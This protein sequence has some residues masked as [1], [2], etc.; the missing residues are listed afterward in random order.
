MST[1]NELSSELPLENNITISLE[2]VD[3]ILAKTLSNNRK[4]KNGSPILTEN[5]ILMDIVDTE[6]PLKKKKRIRERDHCFFCESDVLNFARHVQ[7]NHA[8]EVEVQKILSKPSNSKE[9]K[10]L[11]TSLRKKGNYIKNSQDKIKPM[12]KPVLPETKLMPCNFCLGFYASKQ[13][14]RHKK[15][16]PENHNRSSSTLSDSQNLLLKHLKLNKQLKETVF[17]KM[18]ADN[19]SLEAKKDTLICEFGARY[20]RTHPEKHFVIVTSRKIRELARLLIEIKSLES[21]INNL[22]EALQPQYFDIIIQATKI[23]A[24]YD[25]EKNRFD[26]PTYAMNI[27]TSLKQCCDIA[28]VYALKRKEVYST[29]NSAEA[30]SNLKTMIHLLESNWKF[31]ISTQAANDLNMKKWNKITIVPLASDLK[32]L[33]EHLTL[34]AD[35]AAF[36]L[37]N[38][39]NDAKA[40]GEL[41]ETIYCRIILLNRKR[42]GELQRLLVSTYED[43][44]KNINQNYEEFSDAI[45]ATEKILMKKFR[46][47]VI[48]GK[49]GRGV[50]VLLSPDVQNHIKLL[51]E[52]RSSFFNNENQYLF[53]KPSVNNPICGYKTLE[54]YVKSSGAKNPGA[55][56][57]TRLR[58][59]LATLAQIFNMTENDIE[60]LSTFMGH[61]TNIHKKSYRLPDDVYQT[62]KI[63]KLL[64]LMEKGTSSTYKGKS[65]DEINLDLEEELEEEPLEIE[66]QIGEEDEEILCHNQENVSDKNV[67][68]GQET[69]KKKRK[70]TPWTEKQKEIVHQFF[71]EH[72]KNKVPPKRKE[73]DELIAKYPEELKNKPWLKI[74][75][76]VQNT[77]TRIR[78]NTI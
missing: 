78:K 50:P 76:F 62:A 54:K 48:R 29:V 47:L 5:E 32:L 68:T 60:Q 6:I 1:S 73:C 30:E 44:E 11:L 8:C 43:S 26:S 7:R 2:E 37:S 14:W 23:V 61:T 36:R 39:R 3:D 75:V 28:I 21:S 24:K 57:S 31:D 51:L 52:K 70:L 53:A 41:L 18:R 33:K 17:P 4:S 65:L 35:N 9:R 58:K 12:K 40:Y 10:Y 38:N 72:I 45:S 42:P 67:T 22:F 27:S 19:I 59:H 74:K 77:Y 63:T 46:R 71:K 13:L 49:R 56:T 15:T 20:L 25:P 55:I 16:C 69:K 64:L 66:D 34:K